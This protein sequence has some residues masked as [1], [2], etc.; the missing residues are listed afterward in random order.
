M[1]VNRCDNPDGPCACGAWHSPANNADT[2]D[3]LTAFAA[4]MRLIPE[5]D[6]LTVLRLETGTRRDPAGLVS[7][8]MV[9]WHVETINEKEGWTNQYELYTR[10]ETGAYELGLVGRSYIANRLV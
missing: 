4:I 10:S 2:Y 9:R 3:Y 8:G 7:V 5:G 1:S 6:W